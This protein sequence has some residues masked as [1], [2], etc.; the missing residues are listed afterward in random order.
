MVCAPCMLAPL[1]MA[2]A[3]AGM[4]VYA[5]K[6]GRDCMYAMGIA[7][8]IVGILWYCTKQSSSRRG[9]QKCLR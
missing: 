4:T 8:I 5:R 3:G 9:C 2:G 6:S 1:L 7:T